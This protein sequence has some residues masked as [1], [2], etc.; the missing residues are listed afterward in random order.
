MNAQNSGFQQAFEMLWRRKWLAL[1]LFCATLT[2]AATTVVFLPDIYQTTGTIL[3]ERQQVPEDFVHSTVTTE[4]DRRL[5]TITQT[6]LSRSSLVGLIEKHGLY[7][8]FRARWPIDLVVEQMR[9]DITLDVRRGSQPGREETT[10]AFAVSYR[11]RDPRKVAFVTNDLL[12]MYIDEDLRMRE[13]QAQSTAEFLSTQLEQE[14]R[15]KLDG[16][17]R[18]VRDFKEKFLGELPQQQEANLA[19]LERL[20][21]QLLLN[22][23][24][25]VRLREHRSFLERELAETS[26]GLQSASPEVLSLRIATLKRQLAELRKRFT[27]KYPD[28]VQLNREIGRLEGLLARSRRGPLDSESLAA[29]TAG[30]T[31]GGS[32]DYAAAMQQ[33][34]G[35]LRGLE[36]EEKNL[37]EAFA[38]YQARVENT[39]KR[40]EEL[41]GL[42]R[43]YETTQEVYRS[44]LK[45]YE[46][47]RLSQ[48]LED[49]QKGEQFKILDPALV[50]QRPA[51][52]KRPRLLLVCLALALGVAGGAVF[53]MDRLDTSFHSVDQLRAAYRVPVLVSIHR[54]LTPA[55]RREQRRRLVLGAASGVATITLIAAGCWLLARE[56][57]WFV[58]LLL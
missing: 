42:L 3:I 27:D 31:E 7:A 53:L 30:T 48:H 8:D 13:Q 4:V 35:E 14:L 26:G 19:A 40:E 11:G 6:I 28:V 29:A 32:M 33:V 58:T 56:N 49:L 20:N 44:L 1:F 43:D 25:Q 34:T 23:E 36:A 50:P 54:I 10:S 52:P 41:Q 18:K 21:G 22:A 2:A 37:R 16:Q 39:P 46:E 45:R 17:E 9:K 12:A 47:A 5:Y 15:K 24:K 55:D 51:A 38:Q 57:T